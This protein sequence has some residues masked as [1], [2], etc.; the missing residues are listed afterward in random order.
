MDRQSRRTR[1]ILALALAVVLAALLWPSRVRRRPTVAAAEPAAPTRESARTMTSGP[2]A[3]LVPATTAIAAPRPSEAP[4]IIDEVTVE[5]P[6]VCSGEDNLITVRAHTLNGTDEFLHYVVDGAMGSSVPLRLLL[7]DEGRVE[8]QHTITVFGRTNAAVTVPVPEYKVNACQPERIVVVEPRVAANTWSDFDFVAKVV[9][10]PA[11]A[12]GIRGE[13][14]H[15]AFTPVSYSWSF[16]DGDAATT[17]GPAVSHDYERRAQDS[18]YSYFPVRVD[19]RDAS[20]AVLTGRTTLPLINQAFEAFAQKGIVQLL[21]ALDPRFPELGSDGRVVQSVRLWHT[22]AEPVTIDAVALTR[23][24]EGAAGETPPQAVAVAALLGGTTVPPGKDGITTSVAL[25]TITEPGVFSMTYRLSG[26]SRDGHPVMGS[27]SVMRPPPRPTADNSQPVVDPVLK[28][29]IVAARQMLGK[30]TVNDEELWQLERQGRFAD[31]VPTT[32]A[33]EPTLTPSPSPA[34]A[35]APAPA[36]PPVM[37]DLGLPTRGPPVPAGV[38]PAP[39]ATVPE[40]VPE[41]DHA[42]GKK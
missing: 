29:K 34:P 13:G 3:S 10:L 38:T 15:R 23:Y 41:T 35:P 24:F 4:P 5:K 11:P 8:G 1:I 9:A 37:P 19:V 27:F 30:D 36:R 20:G 33:P 25:D 14:S 31:I 6:E 7:G 12:P 42:P 16:G 2:A 21:V 18:L 28:A 22:R 40:G 17:S 26:H 39:T 32:D